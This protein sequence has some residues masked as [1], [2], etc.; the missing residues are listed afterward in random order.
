M[1]FGKRSEPWE[2]NVHHTSI[3]PEC[4]PF[5]R[6]HGVEFASYEYIS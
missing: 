3:Y 1:V 2:L 6:A 4:V 5:I